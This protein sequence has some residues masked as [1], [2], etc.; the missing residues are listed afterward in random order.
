MQDSQIRQENNGRQEGILS[1]EQ[2]VKQSAAPEIQAAQMLLSPSAQNEIAQI[3]E[4]M[5]IM[6]QG[7]Q[8]TRSTCSRS[9]RRGLA[10][11][12]AVSLCGIVVLVLAGSSGWVSALKYHSIAEKNKLIADQEQQIT[13]HFKTQATKE[14]NLRKKLQARD[15]E[16]KL[17]ATEQLEIMAG[18][19]KKGQYASAF[20][21]MDLF[22]EITVALDDSGGNLSERLNQQRIE[23]ILAVIKDAH[24]TGVDLDGV[25]TELQILS[26]AE[27][28]SID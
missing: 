27:N 18:L 7:N 25:R 28:S 1:S 12:A 4:D 13:A 20:T 17:I 14:R 5:E 9:N 2:E 26:K 10:I 24:G 23:T 11:W 3:A 8:P 6:L 15:E 19:R 21:L 22:K 16:L